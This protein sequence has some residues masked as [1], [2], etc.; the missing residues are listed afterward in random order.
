MK[1]FVRSD[2]GQGCLTGAL[3]GLIVTITGAG[4]G[5]VYL[6]SFSALAIWVGIRLGPER[7]QLWREKHA[8]APTKK[9]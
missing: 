6:L 5:V 9:P 4:T 7:F 8:A 2:G 1:R 3:I